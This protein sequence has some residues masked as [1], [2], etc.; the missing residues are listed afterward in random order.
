MSDELR[1][2][3]VKN[4]DVYKQNREHLHKTEHDIIKISEEEIEENHTY[5]TQ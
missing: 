4:G 2:Y 5:I 1:W 3:I